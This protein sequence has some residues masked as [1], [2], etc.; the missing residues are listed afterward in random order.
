MVVRHGVLLAAIEVTLG[1]MAAAGLT[2]VL[3]SLLFDT[4]TGIRNLLEI[5]Q[6]PVVGPV[7]LLEKCQVTAVG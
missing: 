1:L 2:R 4:C 6:K 3:S 7:T 5:L